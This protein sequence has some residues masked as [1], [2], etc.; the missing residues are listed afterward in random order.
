MLQSKKSIAA[1]PIPPYRLDG[2]KS[3]TE[4]AVTRII[5]DAGRVD[6]CQSMDPY[7]LLKPNANIDKNKLSDLGDS[8][9]EKLSL[10]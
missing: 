9:V 6:N 4:N 3:N 2:Y 7:S 1:V 5:A 10:S 8:M